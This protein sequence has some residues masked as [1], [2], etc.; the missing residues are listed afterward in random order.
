MPEAFKKLGFKTHMLGKW[1]LG[2]PTGKCAP[3][4]RGFD[5]WLGFLNGNGGYYAHGMGAYMDM[6]ECGPAKDADWVHRHGALAAG[7]DLLVENVTVDQAQALC[8]SRDDCIGFTYEAP[9]SELDTP[10]KTYFKSK[11]TYAGGKDWQTW[12]KGDLPPTEACHGCTPLYE[13]QYSTEL[14]AERAVETIERHGEG[15]SESGD[16]FFLYLAWQAV[17]EPMEAPDEYVRRFPHIQDPSR[18]LYAAMLA[19]LDDAIG[20]VTAALDRSGLR[21]DTVIVLS[22]DNGGMSGTYGMGCCNCG[23]SCGGLNYPYR[24]Y[25]DSFFEGG[26]RGIGIVHAPGLELEPNSTFEPLLHVTDWYPTLLSAASAGKGEEARWR[27]RAAAGSASSLDGMDQWEALLAGGKGGGP[28]TEVVIDTGAGHRKAAALRVGSMKLMLG[29]W[30]SPNWCALNSTGD[31]GI[32]CAGSSAPPT[33][34]TEGVEASGPVPAWFNQAQ[35]YDL[36]ADPREEHDLS[37]QHPELVKQLQQRLLEYNATAVPSVHKPNDPAGEQKANE[38][39]C[40]QPW[41]PDDLHPTTTTTAA[42]A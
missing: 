6:H 7:S 41:L 19:A 15:G 25:K 35:L 1:H 33:S 23:T 31:G 4:N 36:A 17:H 39:G 40:W 12:Y 22:T 2:Y 21:N 10:H 32:V 14:Y 13:G 26:M 20:N 24:G 11:F 18:K 42:A 30:G 37:A 3:Y 8:G 27:A 9:A 16:P 5:S 29:T 38:T 28:R 34:S